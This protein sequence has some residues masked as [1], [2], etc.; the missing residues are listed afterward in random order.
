VDG[1]TAKHKTNAEHSLTDRISG[2]QDGDATI[3]GSILTNH[4]DRLCEMSQSNDVQLRDASLKLL[5]VL[6]RQGLV[7]P[8][9]TVPFLFALQGDVDNNFIRA[10]ALRILMMEA[11][12]RPDMIRQRVCAGIVKA[13]E[14]QRTIYPDKASVSALI[15]R[16]SG[17]SAAAESIFDSVFKECIR[18]SRKQRLGLYTN[19]LSQFEVVKQADRRADRKSSSTE[20]KK[21]KTRTNLELL[22]FSS[23]VLA[24]LPYNTIGDPL[25]IIHSIGNI[26]S[27]QGAEVLD[28]LAALLRPV[29]LASDDELDDNASEDALERAART[30]FPKNTQEAKALTFKG[31]DM[32]AFIALCQ[33]GAGLTLLLRLKVYLCKLYNLSETRCLEFDPNAKERLSDKAVSKILSLAPFDTT[34]LI[35]SRSKKGDADSIIRQYAEFRR[36]MRDESSNALEAQLAASASDHESNDDAMETTE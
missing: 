23:Q 2:D 31:F 13:Y 33:D 8:N 7:N 16:G 12:K 29:G 21:K 1:G 35:H 4:A 28:R 6:L 5:E 11:E 3:F 34:L 18:S 30:K 19:L 17:Q 26:V 32:K 22:R 24:H 27:L 14:F 25:F 20:S 36:F 15:E 9:D 10:R